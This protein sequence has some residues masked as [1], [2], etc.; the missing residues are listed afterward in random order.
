MQ[1]DNLR[2]GKNNLKAD[3]LNSDG[4]IAGESKSVEVTVESEVPEFERIDIP[5]GI[6]TEGNE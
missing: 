6:S 3:A 5:E 2:G 4:E 1:I